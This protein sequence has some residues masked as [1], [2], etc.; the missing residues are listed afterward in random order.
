MA[1]F[2]IGLLVEAT[3]KVSV[4]DGGTVLLTK[5][6]LT[7]AADDY[8]ADVRTEVSDPAT[9]SAISALYELGVTEGTGPTP[10]TGDD[11]PG[12]DLF[13][14]PGDTVTRGQMAAFITRALSHTGLRPG[15]V[16]AQYDGAEVVVSVRDDNL[17]PVAGATIDVFWAPTADAGLVFTA[18]GS[19]GQ[20]TMADSSSALCT[21]D[22]T[23]AVTG[24]DGDARVAVIGLRRIP[25]GGATVSAR[26]AYE[27][28][29]LGGEAEVLTASYRLGTADPSSVTEYSLG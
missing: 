11:Q 10:L 23:D 21:I 18:D 16:S 14:S 6:S 8:L 7:A 2:L 24:D 5:G 15:G 17:D 9:R 13:Y 26:I 29:G 4:V 1:T 3:S 28:T 22:E 27:Y 20:A 12:L 19:C 25:E